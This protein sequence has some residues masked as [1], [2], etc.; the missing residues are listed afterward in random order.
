MFCKNCGHE[1]SDDS[2]FC[3]NCGTKVE[4]EVE[5][6]IVEPIEVV[7][8]Y[9]KEIGISSNI[10]GILLG[11]NVMYNES[12]PL[13]I[14]EAIADIWHKGGNAEENYKRCVEKL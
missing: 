8:E 7:E 1:I 13:P 3:S 6:E 5:E 11:R 12:D 14:A 4:R 9:T 10:R 2:K